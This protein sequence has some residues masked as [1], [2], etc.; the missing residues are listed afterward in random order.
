LRR[1]HLTGMVVT[2]TMDDLDRDLI[3]ILQRD[4]KTP[5]TKIAEELNQAD[6]TIH[7]RTKRLREN[8]IVSRF[9]ALV[10]PEALGF[11]N[12]ALVTI[13]IGGHIVPEI[14]KE[15][16]HSFAEEISARND[17][18]WVA[19]SE[20]PPLVRALLMAGGDA[21]MDEEV[22]RLR[23]CPD[24]V[25]VDVIPLQKVVKGWE[26]SGSPEK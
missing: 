16:T 6:T 5:F 19:V 22:E 15:R 2:D 25:S 9:A 18:L 13:E 8:S 11:T 20:E 24:V 10:R 4:A 23:K 7:F 26:I 21:G 14:S 1:T 3:R 12:S 17:Y